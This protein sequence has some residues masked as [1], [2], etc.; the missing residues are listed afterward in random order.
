MFGKSSETFIIAEIGN[1]HEGSFDVAQEMVRQAAACGVDAVKFQTYKTELFINPSDKKRYEQ[2]KAYE[3][4]YDQFKELSFLAKELGLKFIS[5]PF[6]LE[7]VVFLDNIVDAFKV[8]SSDS[9]FYPLIEKI[10]LTGKWIILSTGLC[11]LNQV[12][13][14]A[15]YIHNIWK[16]NNIGLERMAILHCISAYPAPIEQLNL[17]CIKN[18]REELGCVIGYSD[19]ALG[20]EAATT[21]VA[22]GAKV[23]EKHFT[24]DKDYSSFRDHSLSADPKEMRELVHRIR[25]VETMLGSEE[26]LLQPCEV[27]TLPLLR[28]SIVAAKDLP[29]GKTIQ[30]EDIMW[31]RPG[32]G[33]EPGNEV[34]IIGRVLKK[35]ISRGD[36]LDNDLFKN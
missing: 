2:L 31:T 4:T 30:K 10:A 18:M 6:D 32:G 13:S 34:V 5:T 16:S 15:D 7:S 17:N 11:N 20:I 8:S 35:A 12:K 19:H 1:N 28:R 22:V 23:I 24:L 3:L 26:K 9:T 21:A 29:A 33:L 25:S 36:S 14:I 27:D